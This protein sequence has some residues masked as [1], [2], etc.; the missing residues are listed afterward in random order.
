MQPIA[1]EADSKTCDMVD[2]GDFQPSHR[3]KRMVCSE[4]GGLHWEQPQKAL[5][6]MRFCPW[7]GK[8]VGKVRAAEEQRPGPKRPPTRIPSPRYPGRLALEDEYRRQD[9]RR[10]EMSAPRDVVEASKGDVRVELERWL[11]PDGK[12][13]IK[14]SVLEGEWVRYVD[15]DSGIPFDRESAEIAVAGHRMGEAV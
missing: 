6:R 12:P 8:P 2:R 13:H 10:E 14:L 4:C 15:I 7:C 1:K 9:R 11:T 5:P 3:F